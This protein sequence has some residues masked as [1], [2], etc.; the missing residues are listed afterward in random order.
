MR[1]KTIFKCKNCGN[2][3]EDWSCDFCYTKSVFMKVG[4]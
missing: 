2:G 3:F 4:E 1:L